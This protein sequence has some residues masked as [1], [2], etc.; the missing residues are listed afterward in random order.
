MAWQNPY[1]TRLPPDL[2]KLKAE[3]AEEQQK[4]G[5]D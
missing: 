5:H 2:A 3:I 4:V 1:D